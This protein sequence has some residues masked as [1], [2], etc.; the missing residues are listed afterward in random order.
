[1]NLSGW[2][3]TAQDRHRHLTRSKA[4]LCIAWGTNIR[5]SGA[6]LVGK[7]KVSVSLEATAATRHQR[8]GPVGTAGQR[9]LPALQ[10]HRKSKFM[11]ILLI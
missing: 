11:L 4:W 9:G 6:G 8:G 7:R 5:M 2:V 10:R 1:M 3:G